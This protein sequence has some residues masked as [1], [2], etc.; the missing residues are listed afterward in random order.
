MMQRTLMVAMWIGFL[1]TGA[2]GG[3]S[4]DT[5]GE[6]ETGKCDDPGAASDRECRE[7]CGSDRECFTECRDAAAL[8]HCEARKADAVLSSERAFVDD[9]IRWACADVE[10]V[11][12]NM[13]DDR[14]QEYCEYYAVVQPPPAV[15]GGEPASPVD[16]GRNTGVGTTPAGVEL[17]ED[18]IFA[19]EDE[20]DAVVGQCV[21]TS[22][23]SDI[24]VTLPICDAACPELT[25]ADT[26]TLGS[27]M[28]G[29]RG[30]GISLTREMMQMKVGI[31]SNNAA[32]DLVNRCIPGVTAGD[33]A[34]ADDPLHDDY[35][36]G[37]WGS[38]ELFKTEW[39]RS[40]PTICAA[41]M[42]LGE[43]G[44]GVDT[45]ADGVA[46]IT[47]PMAIAQA[48]VPAPRGDDVPLRGFRLGTWSGA[49]E[50]PS[51]C[52]YVDTG[53]DSQTLVGCDLTAADLLASSSDPKN[54]CREK[55][56]NNVVVHI[57]VPSAAVVCNPPTDGQYA[58][59]CGDMV[60]FTAPYEGADANGGEC[61]RVCTSGKACG[62]S[63]IAADAACNQPAGCACDGGA[64]D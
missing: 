53:D 17:T 40:D 47:D 12:T 41:S 36:R 64:A 15:E 28:D 25:V 55:Y 20:P 13:R 61:C 56:G 24:D 4:P 21:F 5:Y 38:Y 37:C 2:C 35:I 26:A 59:T 8:Q 19:L 43:C 11:N 31:N 42:R 34:N 33:P 22:W 57:P 3:E 14:G 50:L 46:D 39:R 51:G 9:A 16:L 60:P 1:A 27:W 10:G 45:D 63:C 30:L 29:Y 7:E 58:G 49:S 48:L 23:H 62:D 54:R 6:C 44:C 18:Q 52:R 32:V